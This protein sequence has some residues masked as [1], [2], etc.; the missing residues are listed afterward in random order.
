M[1]YENYFSVMLE[2]IP[3]YRKMVLLKFLK[4]DDEI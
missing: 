4:N 3:N 2:Y 1:N